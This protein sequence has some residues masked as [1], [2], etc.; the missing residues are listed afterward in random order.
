MQATIFQLMA[1]WQRV[2]RSKREL[3]TLGFRGLEDI[4]LSRREVP[5]RFSRN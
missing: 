1:I 4:G 3:K 5:V 2:R